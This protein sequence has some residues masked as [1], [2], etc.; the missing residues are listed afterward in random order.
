MMSHLNL[1]VPRLTSTVY[2]KQMTIE[3][4]HNMDYMVPKILPQKHIASIKRITTYCKLYVL[5]QIDHLELGV[6]DIYI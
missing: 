2:Y 4:W 3:T 6:G 1:E 5:S